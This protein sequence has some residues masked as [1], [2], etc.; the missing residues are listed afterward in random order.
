MEG[1]NRN[2]SG[3]TPIV[4]IGGVTSTINVLIVEYWR[5]TT[6][7]ATM[8]PTSRTR[9]RRG[10]VEARARASR[11][12]VK[13]RSGAR[14]GGGGIEAR[15]RASRAGVEASR[16]GARRGGGIEARTRAS[17][18]GVEARSG[19]RRGG[20]IEARTRASRGGVEARSGARRGGGIEA[21]TRASRA[22]V[23]ARSGARR[24]GGIE[25]R[26]RASR[27]GV[28]AEVERGG[29]VVASKPEPRDSPDEP[30][31]WALIAEWRASRE[32]TPKPSRGW[33]SMEASSKK[34]GEERSGEGKW[35]CILTNEREDDEW[36]E[37][38]FQNGK[39][40]GQLSEKQSAN[41]ETTN[42]AGENEK[43]RN[44]WETENKSKE[45]W[46]N[47]RVPKK[48]E[49]VG[50]IVI[51]LL[52]WVFCCGLR[53]VAEQDIRGEALRDASPRADVASE[54][55]GPIWAKRAIVG[56][57]KWRS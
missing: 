2:E 6:I 39:K 34:R 23:E 53:C 12:G 47:R 38:T 25:A 46:K 31:P 33:A 50:V 48:N 10:G 36:Q 26:T 57:R 13:A 43:P 52:L 28:E 20:G 27:G 44:K 29:G 17:R 35:R 41:A 8:R 49:Q 51:Y 22:G 1:R 24:G 32:A 30:N 37:S 21:R 40:M 19:A 15:T 45:R 14:R 18:G 11:G 16:S 3:G 55:K 5:A 56:K 9:A 42:C 54:L 4:K 7:E